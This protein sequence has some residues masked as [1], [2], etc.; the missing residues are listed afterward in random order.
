MTPSVI[1]NNEIVHKGF[2][3]IVTGRLKRVI[4]LEFIFNLSGLEVQTRRQKQ[5]GKHKIKPQ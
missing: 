4:Y 3:F 2:K 1:T 5:S